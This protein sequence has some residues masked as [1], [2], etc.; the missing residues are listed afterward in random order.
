M[1]LGMQQCKG[2]ARDRA[3]PPGFIA[4]ANQPML[5]VCKA[6]EETFCPCWEHQPQKQA[7]PVLACLVLPVQHQELRLIQAAT[8]GQAVVNPAGLHADNALALS[9]PAP[10]SPLCSGS[11]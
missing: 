7:T 2:W 9:K 8:P 10:T 11:L 5:P 6:K 4:K 1:Q 3:S